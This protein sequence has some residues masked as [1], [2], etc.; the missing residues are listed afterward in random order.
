MDYRSTTEVAT[1]PET[2]V[3]EKRFV[4]VCTNI[5]CAS[6]GS[7]KVLERL[8]ERLEGDVC[9][10][11]ELREYMC[12]GACHDGPN[13]V[14]YPDRVWYGGVKEVDADAIVDETLKKGEV[15]APLT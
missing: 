9:P 14:L 8:H 6:R 1:L 7:K 5:D 12:F 4:F 10:N 11:V 2:P 13:V 15:V 3:A